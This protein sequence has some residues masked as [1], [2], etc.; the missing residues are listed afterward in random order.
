MD[1][2]ALVKILKEIIKKELKD[3]LS[4]V[5]NELNEVKNQIKNQNDEFKKIMDERITKLEVGIPIG[6]S[7]KF[8]FCLFFY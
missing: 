7:S 6:S 1:F 2:E 5:K 8:F 3:E 4:E